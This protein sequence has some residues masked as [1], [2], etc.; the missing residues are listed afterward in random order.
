MRR[1]WPG[2]GGRESHLARDSGELSGCQNLWE[3]VLLNDL[4]VFFFKLYRFGQGAGTRLGLV[5]G[6]WRRDLW[7]SE[8]HLTPAGRAPG[9]QP[10]HC[11]HFTDAGDTEGQSGRHM[12]RSPGYSPNCSEV[13]RALAS[14]SLDSNSGS[15]TF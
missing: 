4:R 11:L 12:P 3:T 2:E 9:A 14:A 8:G 15:T 1:P 5:S 7:W 13:F 10:V 6:C